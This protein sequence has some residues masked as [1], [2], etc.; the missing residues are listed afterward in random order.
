MSQVSVSQVPEPIFQS[1]ED[2]DAT[3]D[4]LSLKQVHQELERRARLQDHGAGAEEEEEGE[5]FQAQ[6]T[7]VLESPFL[8]QEEIA[9]KLRVI[10]GPMQGQEF[11]IAGLQASVGRAETNTTIVADLAMSRN[12]FELIRQPDSSFKIRDL[13]SANGTLLN[14]AQVSEASIFHGDVIKAG[15]S[16]LHL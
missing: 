15:K 13:G 3:V 4:D 14:G 16:A 9:P 8:T 5:E 7:E 11:F 12:H 1:A 6:R 2:T 10:E